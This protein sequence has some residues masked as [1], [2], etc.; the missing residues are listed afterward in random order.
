MAETKKITKNDD[1]IIIGNKPEYLFDAKS[2]QTI[3]TEPYLRPILQRLANYGYVN[4]KM[5]P[6]PDKMAKVSQMYELLK[7]LGIREIYGSRKFIMEDEWNN[8]NS[9]EKVKVLLVRW[10]M[11]DRLKKYK[12][13][14][15]AEIK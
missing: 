10:E 3:P 7:Y 13:E 1:T 6:H 15:M 9:K 8:P 12:E 5:L 4:I 11:I 2:G 14:L